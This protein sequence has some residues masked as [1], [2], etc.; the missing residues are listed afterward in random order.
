MPKA[1]RDYVENAKAEHP[2]LAAAGNL[3]VYSSIPA[4]AEKLVG[5]GGKALVKGQGKTNE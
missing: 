5:A 1:Q 4:G 3:A 2:I